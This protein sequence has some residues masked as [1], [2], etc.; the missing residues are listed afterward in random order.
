MDAMAR[1]FAAQSA[2]WQADRQAMVKVAGTRWTVEAYFAAAKGEVGLDHYEVRSWHGGYRHMTLAMAA[3]AY[4]V[5]LC[6]HET[7]AP[8]VKETGNG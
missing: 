8:S 5:V 4:L 1:Q 7:E 2:I 6:A 3:L